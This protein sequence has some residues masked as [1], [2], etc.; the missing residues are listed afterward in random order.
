MEENIENS[1]WVLIDTETNGLTAPIFVVELAAQRMRGWTP[2]GLPFRRLLNQNTDIPPEASRVNGYTREILQ[3]DG[4]PAAVVY[5]DFAAYVSGLPIVAFNLEYDLEDVLKPEWER[6][7]IQPIGTAGF[8]A[9]RL[10]QRLL[11]PVPAGNCK[12]QTLRQYYRLPERGAHTALGDVETVTDIMANVLKPIAG[13]R[14]LKSW[15]D[16]CTYA[17]SEWYPSRIA[18]GKF[19]GRFFLDARKDSALLDWLHWLAGSTNNRSAKI[20]R[21]YLGQL[22]CDKTNNLVDVAVMAASTGGEALPPTPSA[23]SSLGVVIFV[24][25]EAEQLRQLIAAARTQLAALEAR[26]TKERHAVDVTRTTIFK[27]LREH[28]QKRDRLRLIIDYRDKYLKIL[29]RSGEEEAEQVADEYQKAKY[30]SDTNYE[31]AAAAAASQKTLSSEEEREL[32]SLWK[33]L[34]RLYHPDRFANQTDKID[35]YQ[36]LTSAINQARDNGDIDMLREIADDPHGF[37]FRQGWASLDFGDV[38]ETKLLRRLYESLQLEILSTMDA[39][40]ELYESSDYT[41]YQL[42]TEQPNLLGDVATE[43]AKAIEAEIARLKETAK[44]LDQEINE[45]TGTNCNKIK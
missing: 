23:K 8:C 5:R 18:F 38:L 4:E 12:L 41:L 21:W 3:R 45:L 25:P 19:K 2:D 1:Y 22:K 34:V 40:N 11:D 27:L 33:K 43:Q 28:Y 39:L 37:I 17:D 30:Q 6:L 9:L 26:Y 44:R 16:I 32:T 14:G 42:S 35:T 10:A 31:N 15:S 13:Q 24:N 29:L 20:G 7:G 36:K